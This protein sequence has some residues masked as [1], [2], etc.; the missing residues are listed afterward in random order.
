[1][2][3]FFSAGPTPPTQIP[4]VVIPPPKS[5]DSPAFWESLLKPLIDWL[6]SPNFLTWLWGWYE[7]LSTRAMS[8]LLGMT[9]YIGMRLALSMMA[10]KELN[11]GPINELA[12]VA[13]KDAFGVDVQIRTGSS[14]SAGGRNTGAASSIGDAAMRGLFGFTGA[15]GAA[16]LTPSKAAAE[17]YLSKMIQ[18]SLEGWVDKFLAEMTSLGQMESMGGLDEKIIN[19]MGLRAISSRIMG[20]LADATVATP[21]EWQINK[22][23]RPRLLTPTQAVRLYRSTQWTRAQLEEELARQGFSND[24][25]EAFLQENVRYYSDTEL[26]MLVASGQWQLGQAVQHL[27][28]QGFTAEQGRTIMQLQEQRRLDAYRRRF[29]D[30]GADAFVAGKID[31]DEWRQ[32]LVLSKLPDREQEQLRLLTGLRKELVRKQLTM[33]EMEDAVKRHVLNINDYRKYLRDEGYSD[34]DAR[35]LELLLL[36]DIRTANEAEAARKKLADDRA[37]AARI[38]AAEAEEKRKRV[39]AEL[40]VKEISL[41]QMEQLVRR[42]LR[43]LEE[44]R[45]LLRANKY[46]AADVDDL[47]E[48][49]AS[50]IED[51]TAAAAERDRLKR[52]AAVRNISLADFETAVKEN[53]ANLD[54]YRAF[55]A[56]QEFDPGSIDLLVNLLADEIADAAEADRLRAEAEALLNVREVSLADVETGVRRGFL[57]MGQY[58]EFLRKEGFE[59]SRISLLVQLLQSDIDADTEARERSAAAEARAAVREISLPQFQRAVRAGV[60]SLAEYRAELATLGFGAADQE[61]L[62]RLMELELAGDA[63]AVKKREEAAAKLATRRVSLAD[64]ERAVKLGVTSIESYRRLLEA[65]GFP[66]EDRQ[67]LATT[68]LAELAATAQAKQERERAKALLQQRGLS[69]V[70]FER[71]VKAGLQSLQGYEA[72]LVGQGF[73]AADARTLAELLAEQLEQDRQA[74]LVRAAAEAELRRRDLTLATWEAAVKAGIRGMSEYRAFLVDEGFSSEDVATLIELLVREIQAEAEAA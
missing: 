69:L 16:G 22:T 59:D 46:A 38:R 24:R 23:Y 61:A 43:S 39:E 36:F 27:V 54:D 37:E 72:F 35:T 55:L 6:N 2:G 5:T 71:A 47:T 51:A 62:L 74:E 45:A 57:S 10:A 12:T 13:V 26:D 9:T 19:A 70:Q 15:S 28:E 58:E 18:M 33:S 3:D 32:I 44:Y 68:L 14:S 17:A 66:A 29:A 53:L 67:L 65:E 73:D 48:L 60:R 40:A 31:G 64:V 63:A 25:M 50:K 49:L 30:V 52:E 11:A 21:F 7:Y 4:K 34:E 1:M 42:G 8:L 56:G 20:P 41:T